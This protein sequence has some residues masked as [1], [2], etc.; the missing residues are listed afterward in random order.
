MKDKTMN[1]TAADVLVNEARRDIDQQKMT[2][3]K[4]TIEKKLK[5]IESTRQVLKTLEYEL[6][7]MKEKI[8]GGISNV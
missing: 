3:W 5:D 2:K 7:V 8:N 6:E 1:K 4:T